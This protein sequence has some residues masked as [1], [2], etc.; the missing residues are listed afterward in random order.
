MY[1][2]VTMRLREQSYDVQADD[3]L[4]IL[5]AA[6]A[7]QE[8]LRTSGTRPEYYRLPLQSRV[9]SVYETFRQAGVRNG[10]IIETIE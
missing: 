7:L 2:T 10:D 8:S 9:V 4:P 6:D 3:N 1:I 5:K